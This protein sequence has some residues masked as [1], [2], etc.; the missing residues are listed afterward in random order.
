MAVNATFY[1]FSKRKNSTAFPTGA[2]TVIAVELK[3]GVDMLN[4][5]FLIA[6]ENQPR[7]SYLLFE[8]RFYFITGVNNVRNGL[9]EI[10]AA[11]DVLATNKSAILAMNAFVLYYS[12]NNDEIVDGRLSTKTEVNVLTEVGDFSRIGAGTSYLVSVTGVDGV[13]VFACDRETVDDL[14]P[15]DKLD[16]IQ[17]NWNDNL[18]NIREV[19]EHIEEV[20]DVVSMIKYGVKALIT[21]AVNGF[22]MLF[23][24]DNS[25]LNFDTSQGSVRNCFLLPVSINELGGT[26]SNILLGRLYS[27]KQGKK[28]IT[29]IIHD[30]ATVTIPWQADD[31]RRNAPYHNIYLYIPYIGL[32]EV[33]A[34]EIIDSNTITINATLDTYSGNAIFQAVASNGSI[35]GHWATNLSSSY[36]IGTSNI[37]MSGMAQNA[38]TLGVGAAAG[39]PIIGIG[40][41]LGM[42]NSIHSFNTCIGFNTGIA[43]QGLGNNCRCIT[44]FHDTTVNPHSIS[45]VKGEPYNGVLSLANITGYVQTQDFSVAGDITSTEKD[46][47]ND[48]M[49]GGVYI[50]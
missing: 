47:I 29:R 19:L 25:L 33:P 9:W 18:D 6:Q 28:G 48:L 12:H 1:N 17:S 36:A 15:S 32:I 24:A 21:I 30:S 38:L 20:T 42:A 16:A 22:I 50:E 45:G 44:V 41:A 34:N 3:S 10:G 40:G 35:I 27:G 11:I 14:M 7:F 8:G 46:L 31:W 37:D 23:E 39:N 5:S 49:D 4:P 43:G 2:G 13:S 26:T